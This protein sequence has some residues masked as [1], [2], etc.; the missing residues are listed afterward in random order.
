MR[1]AD[2]PPD[3]FDS[4]KLRNAGLTWLLHFPDDRGDYRTDRCHPVPVAV[5]GSHIEIPGCDRGS[6][7]RLELSPGRP[8]TERRETVLPNPYH[9]DVFFRN[10]AI[11]K[12]QLLWPPLINTSA[13]GTTADGYDRSDRT[14]TP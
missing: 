7:A 13:D 6:E 10:Q 12:R 3:P 1:P 9:Q 5:A 2:A 8:V 14:T 4:R 11:L